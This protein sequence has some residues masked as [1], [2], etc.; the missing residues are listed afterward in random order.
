[1]LKVGDLSRGICEQ[2][3]RVVET[4]FEY[5]TFQLEVPRID[6]PAVLVSVCVT[7]DTVVAVPYQSS[8]RLNEARRAMG[9]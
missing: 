7:C 9:T 8:P 6:V 1:M 2:C 4:R 3:G 5:R